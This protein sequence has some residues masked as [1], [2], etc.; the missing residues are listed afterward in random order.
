MKKKENWEKKSKKELKDALWEKKERLR[1]LRFDLVS[2]KVKNIR[3]IRFLKKE[4]ARILTA[5]NKK[6][7]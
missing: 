7:E 4:V 5:L 6:V 1:Q 2:G 3:E